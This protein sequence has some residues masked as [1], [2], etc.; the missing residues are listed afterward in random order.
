MKKTK[1]LRGILIIPDDWIISNPEAASRSKNAAV[2]VVEGIP[3]YVYLHNV[4]GDYAMDE[5]S[6]DF[7]EKIK[8]KFPD[9]SGENNIEIYPIYEYCVYDGAPPYGAVIYTK[10]QYKKRRILLWLKHLSNRLKNSN[11]NVKNWK[12][13]KNF[14][15]N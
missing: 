7:F 4:E 6:Y 13:M 2:M 5:I 10:K 15:K 1:I 3:M 11:S 9:F 8:E 12:L 14:L